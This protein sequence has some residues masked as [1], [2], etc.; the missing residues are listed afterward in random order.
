MASR[1]NRKR[2]REQTTLD[3]HQHDRPSAKRIRSRPVLRHNLT[4]V[5]GSRR[6]RSP[7][8]SNKRRSPRTKNQSKALSA[9]A[10]SSPNP[11]RTRSWTSRQHSNNDSTNNKNTNP[12]AGEME[13][14][15]ADID[16]SP[17]TMSH[18]HS[19][20]DMSIT[21]ESPTPKMA[22]MAQN[23]ANIRSQPSTP[24]R[25]N[26]KR[27]S[28][29]LSKSARRKSPNKRVASRLP[30]AEAREQSP[31]A[32]EAVTFESDCESE[33]LSFEDLHRVL[34]R[35]PMPNWKESQDSISPEPA[36]PQK[37]AY[38]AIEVM[39]TPAHHSR[40]GCTR[41][42]LTPSMTDPVA[43][44]YSYPSSH[45]PFAAHPPSFSMNLNISNIPTMSMASRS[46]TY[47]S[48]ATSNGSSAHTSCPEAGHL[49]SN[50]AHRSVDGSNSNTTGS[51]DGKLNKPS[52]DIW[53]TSYWSKKLQQNGEGFKGKL[54]CALV[55]FL[56]GVT[57][58][59]SGFSHHHFQSAHPINPV[60]KT[61][62]ALPSEPYSAR[63][64]NVEQ[65]SCSCDVSSNTSNP[66][67]SPNSC[68]PCIDQYRALNAEFKQCEE[69][70][71]IL[72]R[73]RDR[74][75]IQLDDRQQCKTS[76]SQ[77]R[78]KNARCAVQKEELQR[79]VDSQRQERGDDECQEPKQKISVLEHELGECNV[80]WGACEQLGRQREKLDQKRIEEIEKQKKRFGLC[81]DQLKRYKEEAK[82]QRASPS[83]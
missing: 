72:E 12:D 59:Y 6:R 42:R 62:P 20:M 74:L 37:P 55:G 29:K 75:Q 52:D 57:V 3:D 47:H 61:L 13:Q 40:E 70:Q 45:V 2:R 35:K 31:I 77:M 44:R 65:G 39:D 8:K 9:E 71:S 83:Q 32:T 16:P 27:K 17:S 69:T 48:T 18:S 30:V 38:H 79:K 33:N 14:H 19:S 21:P 49:R 41:N 22:T 63:I 78:R 80:E 24:K 81:N 7:R 15:N 43:H 4:E 68:S 25:A 5:G 82:Q 26:T 67:P 54:V 11:Y 58:A 36:S 51:V 73:D 76:L 34:K 10:K 64:L 23:I 28:A 50:A 60:M 56:A 1:R 66:G 53:S 46:V